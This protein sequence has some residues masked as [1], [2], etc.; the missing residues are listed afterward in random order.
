MFSTRDTTRCECK[1]RCAVFPA[2]AWTWQLPYRSGATVLY[3]LERTLCPDDS[4]D[5][6]KL[7]DDCGQCSCL[8]H[9]YHYQAQHTALS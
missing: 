1:L 7:N 2:G 6:E 4:V 8:T 5:E 3:E 9:H